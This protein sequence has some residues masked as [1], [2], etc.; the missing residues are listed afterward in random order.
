M[1]IIAGIGFAVANMILASLA[2]LIIYLLF[3]FF[4]K[5]FKKAFLYI[6]IIS[7]IFFTISI[8]G[9]LINIS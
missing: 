5:E 2:T 4:N 7:I 9:N 1:D 8:V 6:A 3:K